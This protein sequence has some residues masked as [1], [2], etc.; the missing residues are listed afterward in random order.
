MNDVLSYFGK[1]ELLLQALV[2]GGIIKSSSGIEIATLLADVQGVVKGVQHPTPDL[3]GQVQTLLN[4]LKVNGIIQ[5]Q[6]ID[7]LDAE[8]GKVHTFLAAIHSTPPQAGIGPREVLD[9]VPGSWVFIADAMV[10]KPFGL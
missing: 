5:G 8:M 4:D 10:D 7:Q 1:A 3:V 6:F 9:G 2:A